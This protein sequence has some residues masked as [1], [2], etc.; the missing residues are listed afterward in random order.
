LFGEQRV[1]AVEPFDELMLAIE[2]ADAAAVRR[3]VAAHPALLERTDG[4]GFTPLMRAANCMGR[5]VAVIRELLDAG[6]AVNRQTDEGY[7]ALHLA[8]DVAD[9][10]SR[11]VIA[12]LVAAGADLTLRQHYGW[13]PLL[14]AVVEGTPE[15][16]DALLAAGADPNVSL[17][18]DTL[19]AFNAGL[20]ALM[21]AVTNTDGHSII[22]SLLRAGA[23]PLTRS[24]D[25][26]TFPGY[27]AGLLAEY[28]SGD[29]SESIR[30]CQEVALRHADGHAEPA[31][32]PD[33]WDRP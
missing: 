5:E 24:A 17:P 31:A 10:N 12:L 1:A 25:G 19:P 30:R 28:P 16:V 2:D 20:T 13:T 21:A 14:R 29:F 7:T 15:E 18:A 23:D 6:A 8:I 9:Q 4:W 33:R 32:A 22:A 3:V 27:L 11:E 26:Q